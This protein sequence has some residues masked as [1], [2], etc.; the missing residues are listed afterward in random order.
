[1]NSKTK[2]KMKCLNKFRKNAVA[3]ISPEIVKQA[4]V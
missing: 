4:L 3:F 1:M 2:F